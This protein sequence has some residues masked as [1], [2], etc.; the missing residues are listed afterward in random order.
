MDP[1][2]ELMIRLLEGDDL[3]L[4]QLM[5]RWQKPLVSF[6]LRYTGNE[7]D[8][9]EIA[10]ETFVRLYHNR[11]R[12]NFKSKFSTWLF[13]IATNLARN[14]A[15]W[16]KIHQTVPLESVNDAD[17]SLGEDFCIPI[18][19]TTLALVER[20]EMAHLVQE[21]IQKLPH[22]LKTAIL[23]HEYEEFSYDRIAGILGCSPKAVETR[24]YRA[25]KLLRKKLGSIY[26]SDKD[27]P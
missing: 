6:I 21:A 7:V 15:R 10:Q 14:R 2:A 19:Q 27:H 18:E 1:D 9:I 25:R 8:S 24:L 13:T 11:S 23:L 16:H 26:L 5:D 4:N 12:F 22:D 20:A 3:A 17:E